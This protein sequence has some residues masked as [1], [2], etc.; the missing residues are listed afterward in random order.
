MKVF[1]VNIYI[2]TSIKAPRKGKAAG[3]WLIEFLTSSDIPVTRS[4][5][6]AGEGMTENALA[7]RLLVEAF[8]RLTKTCLVSVNTECGHILSATARA[9]GRP[10]WIQ[11]WE[12]AGWTNKGGKPV[13]NKELW[14]ELSAL[15]R[16]HSVE[17]KN[18]W[19]SYRLVMKTEIGKIKEAMDGEA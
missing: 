13:A 4:G 18:E 12:T 8:R 3:M 15:M 5:T 1:E 10:P 19:H 7:L 17:F 16:N 14:Q 6:I 9:E 2:E 11:E